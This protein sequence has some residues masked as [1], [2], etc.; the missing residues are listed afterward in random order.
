MPIQ[1][2]V[3]S[4]TLLRLTEA[5]AKQE[6]LNQILV[7]PVS[8]ITASVIASLSRQ[9]MLSSGLLNIDSS[10][11]QFFDT[12]LTDGISR[13]VFMTNKAFA[14]CAIA[15]D[16]IKY[17]DEF[18]NEFCSEFIPTTVK[19]LSRVS[20]SGTE[21]E[22]SMAKELEA[23]MIID[24]KTMA[25][26]ARFSDAL[27]ELGNHVK[28][29]E[30]TRMRLTNM[31]YLLARVTHPSIIKESNFIIF[32]DTASNRKTNLEKFI[33]ST[34]AVELAKWYEVF[35]KHAHYNC[36]NIAPELANKYVYP[37]LD[38]LK[39]TYTAII[40]IMLTITSLIIKRYFGDKLLS[41][42]LPKLPRPI[43]PIE[44]ILTEE[45]AQKALADFKKVEPELEKYA[46]NVILLMRCFTLICIPALIYFLYNQG[47]ISAEHTTLV[48]GLLSTATT[49]A[50][51]DLKNLYNKRNKRILITDL[52]TA[53]TTLF[54]PL[55]ISS[56][57]IDTEDAD[58]CNI[59]LELHK[60]PKVKLNKRDQ[61]HCLISALNHCNIDY[62]K[63]NNYIV[64]IENISGLTITKRS[65]ITTQITNQVQRRLQLSE[66]ENNLNKIDKYDFIVIPNLDKDHLPLIEVKFNHLSQQDVSSLQTIFP[67]NT[68]QQQDDFVVMTGFKPTQKK[69]L[70]AKLQKHDDMPQQ[71]SPRQFDFSA[72]PAS[73]IRS[74]KTMAKTDDPVAPAVTQPE[75]TI[76]WPSGK[77]FNSTINQQP[78]YRNQPGVVIPI[79]SHFIAAYSQFICFDLTPADFDEERI[80]RA[81]LEKCNDARLTA[82]TAQQGLV[83]CD[84]E[85]RC[86]KY[87]WQKVNNQWQPTKRER[88]D[89]RSKLKV[90]LLGAQGKGDM[91]CYAISERAANGQILHRV[92]EYEPDSH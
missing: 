72:A 40:I 18:L 32:P 50:L 14:D 3:S 52:T 51:T 49:N 88:L 46:N 1:S 84:E 82:R 81:F 53:V 65:Q 90:K 36:I 75:I 89:F 16:Y 2:S 17:R 45:D 21:E 67:E 80:Y 11:V 78:N 15:N 60:N 66:L 27:V 43:P 25:G 57:V 37:R 22:K 79:S 23:L 85:R 24:T 41:H 64:N 56:E 35:H 54:Q 44:N 77:F 6:H 86:W 19:V 7:Q 31:L 68:W 58:K 48:G 73:A 4:D 30:N 92:V 59:K 42:F 20:R 29:A 69:P 87:S 70:L 26:C 34:S 62:T 8:I 10:L 13:R 76:Q 83:F 47:Y 9:G 39:L 74:R 28:Q 91:R 33:K 71:I 12:F 55:K 5:R 38:E 63:L 61:L